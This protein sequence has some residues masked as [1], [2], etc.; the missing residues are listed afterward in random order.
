[1]AKS[2]SENGAEHEE[3]YREEREV[4]GA[5]LLETI[6]DLINEGTVRRVTILDNR[7]RTILSFPVIVGLPLTVVTT[8]MAPT[9]AA[10]G[11]VG[12]LVSGCRVI[13]ERDL[14]Q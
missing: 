1:M 12:A 9:L 10:V 7:H 13:I 5:T 2:K 3:T 14:Q 4:N 6:Q 8:L 11:A